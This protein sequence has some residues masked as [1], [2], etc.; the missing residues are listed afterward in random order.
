MARK[1]KLFQV[2]KNAYGAPLISARSVIPHTTVGDNTYNEVHVYAT[3]SGIEV[4]LRTHKSKEYVMPVS[5][6]FRTR[7]GSA[8]GLEMEV[9]ALVKEFENGETRRGSVGDW[10]FGAGVLV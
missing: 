8:W 1:N 5:A 6:W 9:K 7:S 3:L 2:R 10:K 4:T